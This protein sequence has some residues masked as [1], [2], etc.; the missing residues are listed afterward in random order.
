MR[1]GVS[2]SRRSGV[3]ATA[4]SRAAAGPVV[5]SW[6]RSDR[7]QAISTRNGSPASANSASAVGFQACRVR[8]S[9][10]ITS[11]MSTGSGGRR[12]ARGRPAV[13]RRGGSA[14]RAAIEG[15]LAMRS[16]SVNDACDAHGVLALGVQTWS[17][18]VAAVERFWRV[19]DD[20]GYA[21][22]T[23]G[24]GP[25]DF[26]PAGWDRLGALA[27]ATRRAR[28]GPAVTYAFDAA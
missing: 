17:T 8:R 22:I 7:M 18:D 1:A 25:G 16:R 4:K 3:S 23:Y 5:V 12:G 9:R 21:R 2:S 28:I 26:T 10:R 24:G 14:A 11:A 13:A 20:L 15:T 19:A 6:V 27:L